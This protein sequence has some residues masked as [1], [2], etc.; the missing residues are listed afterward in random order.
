[1][2]GE[3]HANLQC[4][5]GGGFRLS[6]AAYRQEQEINAHRRPL[7][8]SYLR[9]IATLAMRRPGWHSHDD[10]PKSPF[11]TPKHRTSIMMSGLKDM[12]SPSLQDG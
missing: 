7:G 4:K 9:I 5:R 2:R 11:R 12:L 3:A 8:H 6:V 1:M 10:S